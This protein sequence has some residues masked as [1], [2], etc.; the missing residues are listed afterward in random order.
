MTVVMQAADVG[1]PSFDYA[2][3]KIAR[4]PQEAARKLLADGHWV[5]RTPFGYALLD[6]TDRRAADR[7]RRLRTPEGLGV[8]SM[9]ITEGKA[10]EWAPQTV[11]GLDGSV[12]DRI[13]RLA[14]PAFTPQR[15]DALRPVAEELF[16]E[17][18]DAV[19]PQGHGE[20]ADLCMPYSVR[21][22]FRLLGWLRPTGAR[23]S[24]GRSEQ[25]RS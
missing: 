19:V 3:P 8:P 21:M 4:N 18:L 14:Q 6:W 7:D 9:G 23:S 2:D 25:P 1:M 13:G 10:F 17:I 5:V 16:T 20:G 11:L 12:H 15:L 24:V 22:I